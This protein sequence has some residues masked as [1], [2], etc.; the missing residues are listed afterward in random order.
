MKENLKKIK[1]EYQGWNLIQKK[2]CMTQNIGFHGNLFGGDMLRW[3]DEAAATYVS[4]AIGNRP[5]VTLKISEVLFK[6]PVKA[7]EVVNIDG[8]IT[9]IGNTSITLD[10]RVINVKTNIVVCTTT[11]VF[12][13]VDESM[14]PQQI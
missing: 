2:G 12:V 1:E 8:N 14:N 7:G 3:I 13:C 4:E 5:V 11:M 10:I 6:H 9:K